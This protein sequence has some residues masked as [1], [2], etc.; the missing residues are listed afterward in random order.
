MET[1]ISAYVAPC[2]LS[3]VTFL[4]SLPNGKGKAVGTIVKQIAVEI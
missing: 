1:G 3:V 4:L 2:S